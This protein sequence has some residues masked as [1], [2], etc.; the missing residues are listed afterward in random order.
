MLCIEGEEAELCDVNPAVS[1]FAM[2]VNGFPP[3]PVRQNQPGIASSSRPRSAVMIRVVV[4][5]SGLALP[6]PYLRS[7]KPLLDRLPDARVVTQPS[8]RLDWMMKKIA[9]H[10][11]VVSFRLSVARVVRKCLPSGRPLTLG[12]KESRSLLG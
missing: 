11:L 6:P 1:S 2:S 8:G 3:K 12:P 10:Q 4:T 5:E 7:A 9:P